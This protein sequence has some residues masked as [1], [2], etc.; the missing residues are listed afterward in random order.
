MFNNFNLSNDEIIKIIEDYNPLLVSK[1][2]IN[3]RFDEDLLEELKL[4]IFEELSKNR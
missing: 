1:S 2:Y 3:G 4:C